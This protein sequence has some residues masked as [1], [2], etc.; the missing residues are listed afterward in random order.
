MDVVVA[1]SISAD[2]AR[3]VPVDAIPP[4]EMGTGH[5]ARNPAARYR[6]IIL[7]RAP[8]SGTG[9]WAS[10]SGSVRG[11][12]LDGGRGHGGGRKAMTIIGGGDSARRGGVR[13]GGA[14]W[15]T[16]PPAG[17]LPWNSVWKPCP[18][19]TSSRTRRREGCAAP[20]S[21]PTGRCT[22][23]SGEAAR[24]WLPASRTGWET[25]GRRGV[26]PALYRLD[27]GG[28]EWR[29]PRRSGG[30]G[31]VL[32]A[33]GGVPRNSAGHARRRGSPFVIR[34]PFGAPSAVRGNGRTRGQK[35]ESGSSPRA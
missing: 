6:D 14:P 19:S 23:R 24:P 29:F 22:R 8:S 28:E 9:P 32:A 12:T 30:P 20:S 16:S 31:R 2:V 3:V 17:P 21:P 10:S 18:A 4:D 27:R 25:A 34:R 13:P 35:S 15:I 7:P 1:R 26:V 5:R 11:G 33:P